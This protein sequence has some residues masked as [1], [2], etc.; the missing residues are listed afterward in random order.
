MVMLVT[1]AVYQ[2]CDVRGRSNHV[3]C[4]E[5]FVFSVTQLVDMSNL[6]LNT[7]HAFL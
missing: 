3:F 5:A 1:S 7:L 2:K 4:P 6:I